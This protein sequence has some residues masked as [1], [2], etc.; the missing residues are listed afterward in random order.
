MYKDGKPIRVIE[1]F[2]GVGCQLQALKNIGVP[3]EHHVACEFDPPVHD[4]YE[5]LHGHTQNIGDITMVERIPGNFDLLT[6]S[7]PCQALS[8]AGS[9]GGMEEGSGTTSSLLW[10]VKRLLELASKEGNLP[11][12]LVM[13]NVTQVHSQN[14]IVEFHRFISFLDSIGYTSHYEDLIA[15]DFGIPQIRNRTFMVSWLRKEFSQNY[16]FPFPKGK[17]TPLVLKDFLEDLPVDR[18]WRYMI[19]KKTFSRLTRTKESE[20]VKYDNGLLEES[21]LKSIFSDEPANPLAIRDFNASHSDGSKPANTIMSHPRSRGSSIV[22]LDE[23][24][25]DKFRDNPMYFEQKS[26]PTS[27]S[28]NKGVRFQRS[29]VDGSQPAHVI[30]TS[31]QQTFADHILLSEEQ[32]AC[33]P[34]Y[35]SKDDATPETLSELTSVESDDIPIMV[36]EATKKGYKAAYD[37]DGVYTERVPAKR[38]TVQHGKI[39]TIKTSGIDVGTVFQIG[40]KVSIRYLT[41][42]ESLRLMGWSDEQID[43]I[44]DV[45]PSTRLYKFAGNGIVIQVLE[46]VF[47]NMFLSDST[48]ETRDALSLFDIF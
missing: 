45:F 26:D 32:I 15:T 1:L 8:N 12:F 21:D 4:A 43:K 6:F 23:H 24:D 10:E 9:R 7:F 38:G 18:L 2:S 29:V 37:G 31:P 25:I 33:I 14:N 47:R 27:L 36:A 17:P 34:S 46:A 16:F 19:S 3:I 41:E 39:Q 5:L 48:K 28:L 44:I 22:D 30:T 20:W 11:T 35:L 42:R 13:E 40:D